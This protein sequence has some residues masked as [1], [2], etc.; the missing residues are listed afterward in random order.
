MVQSRIVLLILTDLFQARKSSLKEN[1]ILIDQKVHM[2]FY[3][4]EIKINSGGKTTIDIVGYKM[5]FYPPLEDLSAFGGLK[6]L[7]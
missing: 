2:D 5:S 1:D 3:V 4:V 6:F 7:F